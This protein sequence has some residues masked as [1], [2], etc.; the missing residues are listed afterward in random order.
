VVGLQSNIFVVALL[1]ADRRYKLVAGDPSV[2]AP[3]YDLH[4]FTDSLTTAPPVVRLGAVHRDKLGTV[5]TQTK[6]T[7]SG[8]G[9]SGLLLW[10][11]VTLIL[12]LLI[13]VS[14]KLAR[15]VNKKGEDDRL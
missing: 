10:A 13:Y 15:A 6:T 1:L 2:R 8:L 11:I 3:E 4:F 5:L 9:G 12:L 7:G 14:V